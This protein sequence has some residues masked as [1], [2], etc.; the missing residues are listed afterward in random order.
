MA[1]SRLPDMPKSDAADALLVAMRRLTDQESDTSR[2]PRLAIV[3]RL[4]ETLSASRSNDLMPFTTDLDDEVMRQSVKLFT[5][6]ANTPPV[7]SKPSDSDP[8]QP[9]PES[10]SA[11]PGQAVIQLEGALDLSLLKDVAPVTIARFAELV[12]RGCTPG[13]RSTASSPISSCRA[14]VQAPTITRERRDICARSWTAGR[15]HS[16]RRRLSTRGNDTG[17]GQ[18]FIDLVDLPRLDRNYTVFAYV[19]QGMELIDRVLEG[20]KIVS[21]SVK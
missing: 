15:P 6:L 4:G 9:P 13:S 17:N 18:I 5:R 19:M 2:D 21:I 11:L 10:L 1:L 20:T 8:Y 14:E 7:L 16:R 3:D 12:T